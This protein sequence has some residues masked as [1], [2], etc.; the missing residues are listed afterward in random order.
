MIS[1]CFSD[2]YSGR[3]CGQGGCLRSFRA[4]SL[5][6]CD[7]R[8]Y[9]RDMSSSLI[10]LFVL[11]KALP[12]TGQAGRDVHLAMV[13]LAY[14]LG[15]FAI[16][17]LLVPWGLPRDE[18]QPERPQEPRQLAE[19]D[20]ET[21]VAK[22][23]GGDGRQTTSASVLPILG[24]GWAIHAEQSG[25]LSPLVTRFFGRRSPNENIFAEN[26]YDD[27]SRKSAPSTVTRE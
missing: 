11:D 20:P 24:A 1:C 25:E 17:W 10:L 6:L 8:R 5:G 23:Y 7:V 14:I 4:V 19:L 18:P 15:V 12:T 2:S 9:S 3:S 13:I 21:G 16:A 27:L 26:D 22:I